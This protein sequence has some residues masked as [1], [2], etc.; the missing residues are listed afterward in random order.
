MRS[1]RANGTDI[2]FEDRGSGPALLLL[3]GFARDHTVWGPPAGALER[4]YRL[5]IPDM[6]GMG[7]S[8]HPDPDSPITMEQ[9]A[10]DAAALLGALGISSAAAAGF[11]MGGYVLLQMLHQHPRKVSAA[12]FVGTRASADSPEKQAERLEQNRL[13]LKE[14][15]A[16]LARGYVQKLFSPRFTAEN[17]QIVDETFRNFASQK[18]VHIALLNDAM[19]KREDMTPWLGKIDC[20][21]LVIGGT[22]D[23][24]VAPEAI[25]ALHG[26]LRDSALQMVPGAGHMLPVETPDLVVAALE[27]L[28][29]RAEAGAG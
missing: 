3:H 15:T 22:E 11:S 1:I 6:R 13:I 18:P 16:S 27:G 23:K 24:L 17:P 2:A 4:K 19:R 21:C 10:D 20:P 5:I 14:G 9:L 25:V 7:G 26:K 8:K 28:M 29:R 12:A